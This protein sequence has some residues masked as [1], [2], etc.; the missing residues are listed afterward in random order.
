MEDQKQP[1]KERMGCWRCGSHEVG[2]L[3]STAKLAGD[4]RAKLC[5]PCVNDYTVM[6]R[7]HQFH[8]E[9]VAAEIKLNI[10]YWKIAGDALDRE[11]EIAAIQQTIF[12]IKK[13]MFAMEETWCDDVI[14][15]PQPPP[16]PAPTEEELS[17]LRAKRRRRLELQL[18]V[19]KQQDEE[20]RLVNERLAQETK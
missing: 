13:K 10:A 18:E 12:D 15:R 17:D 4:Y 7:E 6:I 2:W 20:A 5:P 14:E 8:R 3:D 9:L 19:M 1:R 11:K 16:P